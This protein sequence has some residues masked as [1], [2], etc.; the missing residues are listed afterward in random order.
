MVVIL[1]IL[2]VGSTILISLS[3]LI[4]VALRMGLSQVCK[5]WGEGGK[6]GGYYLGGIIIVIGV[7]LNYCSIKVVR[8]FTV[9]KI[10]LIVNKT[11]D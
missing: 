3:L 4:N 9:Q 11:N 6:R 8:T 5:I 2:I 1:T 7:T 10:T